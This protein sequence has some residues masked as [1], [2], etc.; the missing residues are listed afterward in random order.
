MVG[1]KRCPRGGG[2]EGAVRLP[3]TGTWGG[4]PVA[5]ARSGV[6]IPGGGVGGI[7]LDPAPEAPVG[8]SSTLSPVA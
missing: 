1:G 4:G 5:Y 7:A 3:G 6:W 8:C 2:C